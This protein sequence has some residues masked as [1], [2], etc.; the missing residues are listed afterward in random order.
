MQIE[1]VYC[2]GPGRVDSVMLEL[3]EGA[4]LR[5]AVEASGIAARHGLVIDALACGVWGKRAPLSA[6]LRERDRVELYRPLQ[7]D[8]KEARR[9][10]ATPKKLSGEPSDSRSR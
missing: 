8:P 6:V 4:N 10:R 7:C 1:V 5:Q 9:R 2:P 3:P